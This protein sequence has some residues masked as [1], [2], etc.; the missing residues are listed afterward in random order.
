MILF[1][2]FIE[3]V[4][5]SRLFLNKLNRIKIFPVKLPSALVQI[6]F[7]CE[8]K[9]LNIKGLIYLLSSEQNSMIWTLCHLEWCHI[10]VLTKGWTCSDGMHFVVMSLKFLTTLYGGSRCLFLKPR[11]VYCSWCHLRM[12]I[13]VFEFEFFFMWPWFTKIKQSSVCICKALL[14]AEY[15]FYISR[16]LIYIKDL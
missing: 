9:S 2:I 4:G 7:L 8:K 13:F 5:Y 11:A 16:K 14:N 1:G 3:Y 15:F 12:F 6:F 10:T